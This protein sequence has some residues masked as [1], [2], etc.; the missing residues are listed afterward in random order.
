MAVPAAVAGGALTAHQRRILT[1]VNAGASSLSF[2]GSGFIVLCYLL[3]KEL[4]KFSFK[5][6]FYLALSVRYSLS[7]SLSLSLRS[8][9]LR[10]NSSRNSRKSGVIVWALD[11]ELEYACSI[12]FQTL[13]LL[14]FYYCFSKENLITYFSCSWRVVAS[15]HW[16]NQL[17]N[18]KS[19]V[20]K[21]LFWYIG[22]VVMNHQPF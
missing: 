19:T 4:R 22:C 10:F 3:F 5:L 9:T 17:L 18:L 13:L 7:L 21:N 12:W 6:V 8:K 14:L 16:P 20:G 1:A 11:F 15:S 2:A